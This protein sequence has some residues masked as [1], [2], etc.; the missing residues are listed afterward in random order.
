[1]PGRCSV[2]GEVRHA[3]LYRAWYEHRESISEQ[4]L[5]EVPESVNRMLGGIT[6]MDSNPT[7]G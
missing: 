2:R 5:K 4:T 3:G 6:V 7:H 1:V